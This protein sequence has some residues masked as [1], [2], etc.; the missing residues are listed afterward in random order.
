MIGGDAGSVQWVARIDTDKFKQDAKEVDREAKSLGDRMSSSFNSAEA[1]SKALLLGVTAAAAG[2][3]AFGVSSVKAFGESQ[4]AIS[5]TEAV[6]KSTGGAAG[7]TSKMVTDLAT[8]LQKSTRF[9][10]EQVRSAENMLLTFTKIGKDTFP[11]ATKAVAD[12]ATAMGT[13]LTQTSIQVGKAL[14]DPVQGVTALQRVGVRLSESQKELVQRLVDTG[15]T[16]GAQAVIL[17]ELQTEF[18]GSAEAAGNTLPGQLDKLKNAFNDL[19][20]QVGQVIARA[21]TPLI[22]GFGKWMDK[23]NEAGGLLPY[24][25]KIIKE[26]ADQIVILSGA[27]LGGLVPALWA[28]VAPIVVA[29]W[30]L[31]PFLI[32]GALLAGLA[33]LIKKNWDT[34]G[35]VFNTVVG[36]LQ[37]AWGKF[38]EFWDLIKPFRDFIA[39]QF[40]AAWNDLKAAFDRIRSTLAPYKEEIIL[41][42]KL[43]GGSLLLTIGVVIG[44][45]VGLIVV[46]AESVAWFARLVGWVAQTISWFVSLSTQVGNAMGTFV[47]AIADKLAEAILWFQGLPGRITGAIGGLGSS[48][49]NLGRDLIQGF[50]NGIADK[51]GDVKS[52]LSNLTSKLTSW[53]GPESLD[54]VLLTKN[55]Q[56]IIGGFIRGLESQYPAVE[57][58]LSGLTTSIGQPD[59][60]IPSASTRSINSIDSAAGT[61]SGG[62]MVNVSMSGIMTSSPADERAI[63]QRLVDRINE[64]LRAKGASE[65]GVS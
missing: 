1:G 16:A 9:S 43:M 29:M 58:S 33:L 53:K 54:K 47:K 51:F 12:M 7:V 15:N 5:Q 52:T 17:K 63:A 13:D 6:L 14:Q 46:I 22:D 55:G 18:G 44:V 64:S 61:A 65:L 59:L 26:H 20:E 48:L 3:V 38:N 39:S 35:P 40:V 49:Y 28:I 8:S 10:D 45:I 23:V 19:Q 62:V 37:E 57:R 32:A 4:L 42:A 25:N 41:I 21:L 34:I 11:E 24:F 27:I 56:M 50:I 60:S 2:A 31:A 36:K 30:H